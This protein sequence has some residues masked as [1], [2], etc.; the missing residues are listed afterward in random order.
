MIELLQRVSKRLHFRDALRLA[1]P[2][3]LSIP[4]TLLAVPILLSALGFSG[5]GTL[6]IFLLVINQSHLLLLG[7]EK[8]L[9]RGLISGQVTSTGIFTALLI[10]LFYGAILVLFALLTVIYIVSAD[11]LTIDFQIICWLLAGIPL[12]FF[13]TIQRSALQALEKFNALAFTNF[14]YMG[15]GHYAPLAITLFWPGEVKLIVFLSGITLTRLI[16]LICFQATLMRPLEMPTKAQIIEVFKLVHYGK[17]MGITQGIQMIFDSA[18]RYLLNLLASSSAVALYAVPHQV[19]QKIAA[20]PIAMAHVIFNKSVENDTDRSSDYLSDLLATVPFCAFGFF[21]L[22]KPF[23]TLWLGEH[24][25]SDIL[26]LAVVSF[27]AISFTSVNFVATSI[28]ESSGKAR[29]LARYDLVIFVP[30][31]ALMAFAIANY[32][33]HGAAFSLVI[34]ELLLLV[35]RLCVLRSPKNVKHIATLSTIV[36]CLASIPAFFQTIPLSQVVLIQMIFAASFSVGLTLLRR[37]SRV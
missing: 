28:I 30:V 25:V 33:A 16:L 31:L 6:I 22:A 36:L 20:L 3:F 11:F 27:T 21:C 32:G 29:Q 35:V 24:F 23:F 34:R 8:N 37:Q 18:D 7:S 1:S 17:W 5:Y 10:A 2:S 12:H 26:T 15:A 19:S 14:A 4:L 9:V 13:W